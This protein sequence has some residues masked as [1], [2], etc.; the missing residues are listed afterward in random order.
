MSNKRELKDVPNQPGTYQIRFKGHLGEQWA[1]WFEGL[2]VTLEKDGDTLLTG[3]VRDQA[4][5]FG[6]F[7]KIRDLGLMLISVNPIKSSE[8]E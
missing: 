7:K 5:L 1:D 6:L 3:P 2:T 8:K 4:A